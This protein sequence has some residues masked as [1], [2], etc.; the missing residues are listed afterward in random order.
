MTKWFPGERVRPVS[1]QSSEW[2]QL[3]SRGVRQVGSQVSVG[4]VDSQLSLCEQLVLRRE[5]ATS[6]FS[7]ECVCVT[8]C[9]P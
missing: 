8:M 5:C 6:W 4:P 7:S 2:D 9:L 1:S 3:V